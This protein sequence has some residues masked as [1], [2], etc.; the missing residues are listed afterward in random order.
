M[1]YSFLS[2]RSHLFIGRCSPFVY[3]FFCHPDKLEM[4]QNFFEKQLLN[5]TN[6]FSVEKKNVNRPTFQQKPY[7]KQAWKS[8]LRGTNLILKQIRIETEALKV[9]WD[10]LT[11]KTIQ[12]RVP[13]NKRKSSVDVARLVEE[14]VLQPRSLHVVGSF[15]DD[16]RA[17]THTGHATEET[18]RIGEV[19]VWQLVVP[20]S[21][22]WQHCDVTSRV[23]RRQRHLW[24]KSHFSL[25]SFF[26]E[27]GE[28]PF[29]Y[30]ARPSWV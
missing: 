22:D 20:L 7:L 10:N 19:Q 5:Q 4:S 24:H 15:Y 23:Q 8:K 29:L 1:S 16:L 13:T 18:V 9:W 11:F 27:G 17:A 21:H 3:Y 30:F 25:L 6:F 12:W 2:N 14:M 28:P 26:K